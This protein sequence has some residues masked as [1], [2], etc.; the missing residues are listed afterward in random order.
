MARLI[1]GTND[2]RSSAYFSRI[3][4]PNDHSI[5]VGVS[6][7]TRRHCRSY[8]RL[9]VHQSA[10]ALFDRYQCG[11]G[12]LPLAG[13]VLRHLHY[14]PIK[15]GLPMQSATLDLAIY[16]EHASLNAGAKMLKLQAKLLQMPS[17]NCSM[18]PAYR[19]HTKVSASCRHCTRPN[20]WLSQCNLTRLRES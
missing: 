20:L 19:Q 12:Y 6:I 13:C 1:R 7:R 10:R 4:N 17:K 3:I 5:Q 14:K 15:V 8:Q 16:P 9:A 11:Q 18:P 2:A